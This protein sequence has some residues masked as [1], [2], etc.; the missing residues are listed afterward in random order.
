MYSEEL[1]NVILP[2]ARFHGLSLATPNP[3]R[4]A[5][6]WRIALGG[7]S[8]NDDAGLR[9]TPNP[10]RPAQEI[11]RLR[12]ADTPE[13]D[14]ARVHLDLRLAGAGPRPLVTAGASVV[15]DLGPDPWYV[16]ADPDGNEFCTFP[17]VDG[18][19]AGIFELVV[20]CRDA[21][22]LA[23]WW[24]SV[25]G[26][27]VEEEG[28]SA[29]VQGSPDFPW[30][31]FVFDPVPEAKLVK[32]RMHWHLILRDR[33]PS[34]LLMAGAGIVARPTADRNWWVLADPEG[35]EFCAATEES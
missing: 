16:L 32:N 1:L 29:A 13:P 6:F 33:D 17:A 10:S 23:G 8:G 20:K 5:R 31:Y 25:I 35:N 7:N 26:G 28:P 30:D 3:A 12:L 14:G 15:R 27:V 18:R 34:A 11:L 19:P 22:A 9:I 2:P 24:A 21:Y 4:L